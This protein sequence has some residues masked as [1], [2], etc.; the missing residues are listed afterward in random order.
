[1]I[2][3]ASSRPS[4]TPVAPPAPPRRLE[5]NTNRSS[6]SPALAMAYGVTNNI[7]GSVATATRATAVWAASNQAREA[8]SAA[9]AQARAPS[10]G[11]TSRRVNAAHKL[12]ART[13][14]RLHLEKLPLGVL[15]RVYLTFRH[16]MSLEGQGK[17][18]IIHRERAYRFLH[19]NQHLAYEF[20]DLGK[21]RLALV[22]EHLLSKHVFASESAAA[23]TFPHLFPS[24]ST[25]SGSSGANN[26][27]GP[28][29]DAGPRD[30]HN[31][32]GPSPDTNLHDSRNQ[33]EPHDPS[34][35]TGSRNAFHQPEPSRNAGSRHVSYQSKSPPG[36]G[37]PNLRREYSRLTRRD[38]SIY[39]HRLA[40][41][42]G[43]PLDPAAAPQDFHANWAP[44]LS[45]GQVRMEIKVPTST[46][47]LVIGRGGETICS[48]EER[49]GCQVNIIEDIPSVDG[50]T[51]V[52]LIGT[53]GASQRAE[54]LIMR[55]V[56]SDPL[57]DR[58]MS[59]ESDG[60]L[61]GG[62]GGRF[63]KPQRPKGVKI[64]GQGD[65]ARV[66][67]SLELL[68]LP[69][70]IQYTIQAWLKN[71]M[72]EACFAFAMEK[73]PK[74]IEYLNVDCGPALELHEWV[75]ILQDTEET[76][77]PLMLAAS[78]FYPPT[79][80]NYIFNHLTTLRHFATHR[81]PVTI[82]D[83]HILFSACIKFAD[84]VRQPSL[85][86]ELERMQS[87]VVRKLQPIQL[88]RDAAKAKQ[89]R[90][91]QRRKH[92]ELAE[93]KL[94]EGLG[95]DEPRAMVLAGRSDLDLE[96]A[97]LLEGLGNHEAK[98]MVH[99]WRG[100]EEYA[101]G[102]S[103]WEAG[104]KDPVPPGDKDPSRVP[105]DAA[106]YGLREPVEDYL[107]EPAG[108]A[109]PDA[110]AASARKPLAAQAA[111]TRSKGKKR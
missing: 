36:R 29:P 30:A 7:T 88:G 4:S 87:V 102:A 78:T 26:Q 98:A 42:L 39:R 99:A 51:L 41:S 59:L 111:P 63:R 52:N 103:R 22:F 21:E 110:D 11:N 53:V 85:V 105:G 56:D 97:K 46:V 57:V 35:D 100:I 24:R 74:A 86:E 73:I 50:L 81:E 72:E 61:A 25:D 8:A 28:P 62:G 16:P 84:M 31:Q 104:G 3:G 67:D 71:A 92:L 70:K 107:Q 77:T 6:P 13:L 5:T 108:R 15:E 9:S 38:S 17:Y 66:M 68:Y 106:K 19:A 20:Q 83:M 95:D 14:S 10:T 23:R 49:S 58:D 44:A 55:L 91:V 43:T 89:L 32:S 64:I 93:A 65:S 75:I 80:H 48:I 76:A 101:R 18:H 45:E 37:F 34:P 12:T 2:Y 69:Y 82:R 94:I 40:S 79:S 96:E 60:G 27:S 1:G 33:P 109:L 54:E 47:K 90:I